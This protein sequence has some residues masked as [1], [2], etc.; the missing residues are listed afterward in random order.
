M[1]ELGEANIGGRMV[2]AWLLNL[3]AEELDSLK[4]HSN[5]NL[6]DNWYF[7]N[8]VDQRGG[9][10]VPPGT[11]YF[12]LNTSTLAGTTSTYVKVDSF[13]TNGLPIITI[14][15]TQYNTNASDAVRGYVG[16]GY[17]IDRWYLENGTVSFANGYY[18]PLVKGT[19][20]QKISEEKARQLVGKTLTISALTA[21]GLLV[22]A[23][24]IVNPLDRDTVIDASM[25]NTD[26]VSIHFFANAKSYQIGR[27]YCQQNLLAVK[28]ELGS[29]QTLAHQENG[30]W[31]LNEIPDYGEQ[32]R[33]CQRYFVNFNPYKMAW[34][35]MPPA[36]TGA[37]STGEVKA[38]SAVPLP[39]AMRAQPTVSYGGI[40]FLSQT[41]DVQVTD[42]RVSSGT[43]AGNYLQLM[44]VAS[45]GL[46]A[47]SLY[48]VQGGKDTTSYIWLSA[49]L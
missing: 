30:V 3:T 13:N 12:V 25:P 20:I 7:G 41:D 39:V 2:P 43:F 38:F 14:D 35:S 49:D 46:A 11:K 4:W 27:I 40:I 24:G 16:A 8:P 36:V 42:I 33:R 23:S 15:G 1:A 37:V 28:S 29:Q 44:Y 26:Y 18:E 31:V 34:F 48:R 19:T 45:G 17:G 9:Y 10:V 5:R 21:D 6:L 47:N 32:L 22:S